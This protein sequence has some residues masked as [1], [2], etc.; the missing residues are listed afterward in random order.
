MT[1]KEWNDT[2]TP[3]TRV[4]YRPLKGDPRGE[5]T[6]TRS[7]A[8]ELG[9]GHPVVLVDGVSGGVSLE[10]LTVVKDGKAK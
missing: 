8:W 10:H 7:E 9:S 3:G 1:A 2:Y 4:A 5:L 6:R